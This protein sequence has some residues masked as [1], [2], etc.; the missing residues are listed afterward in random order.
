MYVDGPTDTTSAA[1]WQVDPSQV[2]AFAAA[3]ADVRQQL[4]KITSEVGDLATPNFAPMLGTSPVGQELAEKFTDRLGSEKG[5]RGQLDTAVRHMEEFVQAAENTA[6]TY[7]QVDTNNL[8]K[9]DY[10]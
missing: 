4:N 7:T 1:G 8:T 6:R 3:V 9:F 10:H 5:L 2:Q